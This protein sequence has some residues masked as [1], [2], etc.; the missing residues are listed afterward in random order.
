VVAQGVDAAGYTRGRAGTMALLQEVVDAVS[1][2]VLAAGGIGSARG[3]AA[4][5][6]AGAA[7]VRVGTRFV[8]AAEAGTEPAYV[9]ALTEARAED[10]V[11]TDRFA[12]PGVPIRAR[13]IAAAVERGDA[14]YAGESTGWVRGVQPA[15]EIVHELTD[16]A[17]ELLLAAAGLVGRD[18]APVR[19]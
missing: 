1:V 4:A 11:I 6:A 12:P 18:R 15:A 13:A 14:Y 7:G 19:G 9:D 5:L 2:P 17:E 3:F 16:G 8:A 10:T